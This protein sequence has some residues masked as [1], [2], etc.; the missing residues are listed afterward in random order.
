MENKEIQQATANIIRLAHN[1]AKRVHSSN[2]TE[3]HFMLA[4]L[5]DRDNNIVTALRNLKINLEKFQQQLS[6][7][8]EEKINPPVDKAI[9]SF[10]SSFALAIKQARIESDKFN[11]ENIQAD[12]ILLGILRHKTS[13]VSKIINM[14]GITYPILMTEFRKLKG[15]DD[16]QNIA[17]F[18]DYETEEPNEHEAP[19]K[20]Q[21]KPKQRSNTPVLDNFGRDL[22]VMAR[23]GKLDPVIGREKEIRRVCEIISRRKKNN[24]VLIG[25]AGVGKTAIIEGLANMIY[26]GVAPRN[27]QDKRIVT[28]DLTSLVAGTKYRGQF[29]ERLKGVL[30]ELLHNPEVVLFIDEIHTIVG[31]GNASGSLDA[32]NIFKPALAKG[33]IQVIGSTTLDEYKNSIEKDGAL[34]RRFQPVTVDPPSKEETYKILQNIKDKYESYHKVTYTDEAVK[35]CV[36]LSDKYITDRFFPDKAIDIMDEVGSRVHINVDVPKDITELEEQLK[37]VKEE[38]LQVVK[39][40]KYEKAADLR[41]REVHLMEEV[42]KLRDKWNNDIETN[43]KEITEDN[44]TEVVANMTGIPVNKISESENQK[45]LNMDVILKEKIMGQDEAITKIVKAVKR[46]RIGLRNQKRPIGSFI[47]LGPTGV[48]KTH[49]AKKIAEQLFNSEDAL[50]RI[51]MTEYMEKFSV[52]RLIGAPPGYVGYDE[53]GQLTEKVRR[54]P[55]SVV[56]LDE[57]EKAHPDVFN[58]L[59]QVLDDGILTD[60]SGVKVNF[61]NTLVIMTSNVGARQV[62]DFGKGVGFKTAAIE[63][64][65]HE[66]S[67]I[68]KAL[69]KTFSPEFLNRLD[70]IIIFNGL[71]K[72]HIKE[73][74]SIPLNALVKQISDMG[75]TVNVEDAVKDFLTEK[76]YDERYGARPLNRAIQKYLE[77][78]ISDAILSTTD[79][80]I[81][82]VRMDKDN[83]EVLV[84]LEVFKPEKTSL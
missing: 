52:S 28:L 72:E 77:D 69:R 79:K 68:D 20:K 45:L 37:Q 19:K 33:E 55:Y 32:S 38:K 8:I 48:G 47:F 34:N 70:D 6:L 18:D 56:L 21:N 14:N 81:L 12:H 75:Y 49:L 9:L 5:L 80:G 41:D 26:Q 78:P 40:Q 74:V 3:E 2:I 13:R 64:F 27:L 42:T 65:D 1:E 71:K 15:I 73:I 10:S 57:I 76:G 31:A 63:S 84:T 30:D 43:R 51:D 4:A 23:E 82:N 35:A 36:D 16:V 17:D 67:T 60:S 22:I 25:E 53:G 54:K 24:P 39:S 62:A 61:K 59:L 29:E 7:F 46:N 83:E 11:D 58:I 50:I 66:K 44:V